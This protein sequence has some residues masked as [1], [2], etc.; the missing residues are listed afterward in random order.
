MLPTSVVFRC[1]RRPP[2]HIIH[3]TKDLYARWTGLGGAEQDR[4]RLG[5]QELGWAGKPDVVVVGMHGGFAGDLRG[6][7][8]GFVPVWG[9]SCGSAATDT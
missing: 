1:Y 4:A 7:Q 3:H 9:D 6:I 2:I 5:M 8:R